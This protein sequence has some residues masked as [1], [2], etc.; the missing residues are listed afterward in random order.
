MFNLLNRNFSI[1]QKAEFD[2]PAY[3]TK[4]KKTI[5]SYLRII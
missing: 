4:N 5:K 1:K 3:E 2:I